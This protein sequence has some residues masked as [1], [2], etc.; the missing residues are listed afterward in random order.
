M[1]PAHLFMTKTNENEPLTFAECQHTAGVAIPPTS[2]DPG[3]QSLYGSR[4][5]KITVK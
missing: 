3:D 4:V 1:I 5:K 2:C